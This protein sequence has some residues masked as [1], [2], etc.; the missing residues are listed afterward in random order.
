[1]L[2][3]ADRGRRISPMPDHATTTGTAVLMM[4]GDIDIASEH[5]WRR[6]GADLFAAD[7]QLRALV[8]DLGGVGFLDSR[9]MATL[10]HLHT[11]ALTRGGGV[12]LRGASPRVAKALAVAGLNQVLRIE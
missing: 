3:R 2:P 5:T 4:H 10:V 8:V 12:T 9:G 6:R 7:P 11:I 1:M